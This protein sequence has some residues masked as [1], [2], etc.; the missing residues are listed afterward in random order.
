MHPDLLPWLRCPISQTSLSLHDARWRDGMIWSGKL[1]SAVGHSWPIRDGIVDLLPRA[2]AWNGAQVVN[3]LPLAAW[4]YERLWRWQALSTLSGRS[5]PVDEELALLIAQLA[6]QRGG[7]YLD[8]ACSNGL[9]ARAIAAA[10]PADSYCIA[11]DHS[12]PMLRE[13]QRR[14]RAKRLKISYIRG[15]AEDLPFAD[16]CLAGVACGGS[17]NEFVRPD[18]AISEVRRCLLAAGR[19]FW[20]QAQQAASRSGRLLQTFL[21]SGGIQFLAGDQFIESL[22]AAGLYVAYEQRDGAVQI[23]ATRGRIIA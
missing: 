23:V 20:M 18:R 9:Y 21:L 10:L 4:G 14:S 17:I 12:L 13:A 8:L 2:A 6:P 5:F 19:S 22:R 11:L 1:V 16:Q 15:L 7:V 3:R